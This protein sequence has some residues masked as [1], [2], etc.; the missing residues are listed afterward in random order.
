MNCFESVI[1]C[2]SE[3][4]CCRRGSPGSRAERR[5]IAGALWVALVAVG[6]LAATEE[7]DP[8]GNAT[9][10]QNSPVYNVA[11]FGAV[12]DGRTLDTAAV[13]RAVDRAA[14]E[15]GGT[16]YLPPGDYLSGTIRLRD[17]VTLHLGSGSTIW[18]S[19]NLAHYDPDHKH[20]LYAEAAKNVTLLGQGVVHGNGPRFWD[21]ERLERW[22]R[23]EIDLER[24]SDMIRFDH[25]RNIVLE[26]LDIHYGAFWNIG[27]GDCERVTLRGITMRNGVYEEDGPNTDG[28]NLWNCKRV[29]VSDCD[30]ITG[31][32]CI[33]VLGESRDVTI[34][35]C[36]LQT[37][38]TA[39]MISGVRNLAFSNSTIHDSGCGIGFRV[40]NDIV[41][42]GVVINNIVMDV[43]DRFKGG[44]TAIYIWSFPIYVETA[45]PEEQS[46]PPPGKLSHVTISDVVAS[47][48]GLVC[49]NGAKN[50]YVTGLTLNNLRFEMYGGK[51]SEL[52]ANP[53]YP[54]PIYG[55]HH[56]SPYSMFFRHVEDLTLRNIQLTW[57][58]PEKP[59][60]GSALRCWKVNTVDIDGFVG[61]QSLGSKKPA[62]ELK[63]VKQAF[64]RNCRAPSGTRTFLG[65]GENTQDVT[66]MGNDL[67]LAKEAY[68][69]AP[70][71]S[72]EVFEQSNRLPSQTGRSVLKP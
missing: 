1:D 37:S 6:G 39:L 18:G 4:V 44:G 70:G 40:W 38:E 24:T 28:I 21:N 62:I 53:P 51:T 22:L 19:T 42:D 67:H 7:T 43:S 36:K 33:V 31:D 23:G 61:R 15:G 68:S 10:L 5:P 3:G 56:A 50:G 72:P 32:D 30:I 48:N 71:A 57:N 2:L 26:D 46:L 45:V 52:N 13:Q 58:T 16:V 34:T 35:N 17:D 27:F 60:W 69:L 63:D 8:T 55:F 12:G 47:A 65:L 59:E 66:I 25:C 11:A 64:V 20:L 49:V 54:Y 14:A 9:S 41:V 29:Q